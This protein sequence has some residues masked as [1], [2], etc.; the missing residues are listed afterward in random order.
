MLC[1]TK[2]KLAG[3]S[4]LNISLA[5]VGV[6]L[7]L[8][9]CRS[10]PPP[11]AEKPSRPEGAKNFSE[12]QVTSVGRNDR[13]AFSTD[14]KSLFYV[15]AE[16]TGHKNYQVYQYIFST[17][18]ERRITFHDGDDESVSPSSNGREIYYA[19]N[20]DE[21]KETPDF[22]RQSLQRNYSVTNDFFGRP[23]P[24]TEIYKSDFAGDQIERLIR[25]AGYDGDV[26]SRRGKPEAVFSSTRGGNLDIYFYNA[27]S[28]GF[29][30][31]TSSKEPEWSPSLS[32]KGELAFVRG[33]AGS[34]AV[35]VAAGGTEKPAVA[36]P[37]TT[38]GAGVT[39]IAAIFVAE[40]IHA[41]ARPLT[42]EN[43]IHLQPQWHPNNEWL[44]FSA[45]FP[46]PKNFELYW[47]R[48]DGKCLER[49]TY[50]AENEFSPTFSPDGA[51]IAFARDMEGARQIVTMTGVIAPTCVEV[52]AP[53]A[54]SQSPAAKAK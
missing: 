7:M 2:Q 20:T 28:G 53:T 12:K 29:S 40:S 10:G 26:S 31:V 17:E 19:S 27:G 48:K 21:I 52:S 16:R 24:R 47:V 3:K 36:A 50:T 43:A 6:A 54:K 30:R 34:L 33:M 32:A 1:K 5:L 14:G 44:I 9:S 25:I 4:N 45:N 37:V 41:K 8:S 39:P 46:D 23:L 35:S 11:A 51:M 13:P 15:A 49:L 38:D 22:I 18:R 42:T